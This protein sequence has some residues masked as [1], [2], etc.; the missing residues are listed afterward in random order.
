[1]LI[2]QLTPEDIDKHF[3]ETL[4]SFGG[5][6]SIERAKLLVDNQRASV[7][8]FV[9]KIYNETVG[10]ATL[11]LEQKLIHDG[12]IVGH[13]EDVCVHRDWRS[14]GIGRALVSFCAAYA[15]L[16]GAYKVI[17]ACSS[18]NVGFYE[19]LGFKQTS[20][21][22]RMDLEQNLGDG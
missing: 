6:D 10:T 22:M 1:M 14:K 12:G 11:L 20:H 21:L 15:K 8:T 17:L 7:Y 9:C 2:K 16:H 3:A 5:I 19:K 4:E 13:I 18:E